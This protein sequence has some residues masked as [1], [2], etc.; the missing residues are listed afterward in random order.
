LFNHESPLRPKRFVTQKII[1]TAKRISEGSD[2]KLVLGRL[3]ISRDWG[4]APEYVQA[5]WAML[6]QDL[7][8]DFVIATGQTNSLE[9]FV[10]TA[11]G[12]V[13]LDWRKHVEQ[14]KEFMRPTDLPGSLGDAAKARQKL[15]WEAKY[16]MRD[17]V[18]MMMSH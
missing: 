15:D 14:S 11:F 5:M 8:E 2:E 16:K 18:R 6:Q 12:E 1:S 10:E 7:P 9:A 3:D 4:W 13:S 17:V